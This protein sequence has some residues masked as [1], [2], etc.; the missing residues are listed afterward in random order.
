M[1]GGES[2]SLPCFSRRRP[3]GCPPAARASSERGGSGA[4][5]A[6]VF[7][8]PSSSSSFRRRPLSPSFPSFPVRPPCPPLFGPRRRPRTS[9]TRRPR[10]RSTPEARPRSPRASRSTTSL[11]TA[12]TTPAPPPQATGPI[13]PTSS[14]S[15]RPGAS[16]GLESTVRPPSDGPTRG[17]GRRANRGARARAKRGR[18]PGPSSL[19]RRLSCHEPGSLFLPPQSPSRPASAGCIEWRKAQQDRERHR[20]EERLRRGVSTPLCSRSAPPFR[21][22]ERASGSPPA[23]IRCS[24]DSRS[25]SLP[26]ETILAPSS[27]T[28]F[29]SSRLVEPPHLTTC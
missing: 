5:R 11:P 10:S 15:T 12:P 24:L 27:H 1:D 16:P 22:R 26:L 4:R 20:G 8:S 28:H 14:P 9:S 29:L 2:P 19:I 13:A 7:P 21:A 25:P 18:M 23:L 17:D 3:I 6:D